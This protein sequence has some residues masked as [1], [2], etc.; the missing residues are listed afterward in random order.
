MFN[1]YAYLTAHKKD[2]SYFTIEGLRIA[3]KVDK[4]VTAASNTA[5]I[6]VY[7][8]SSRTR[9]ELNECN[10]V[11]LYAGYG[12]KYSVGTVI[13]GSIIHVTSEA[14]E[15]EI[16]TTIEVLDGAIITKSATLAI[17]HDSG[18]LA[19]TILKQAAQACNVPFTLHG[20]TSQNTYAT[21]FSYVGTANDLLTKVCDRLGLEWSLQNSVL[22]IRPKGSTY[23]SVLTLDQTTGL[24]SIP[25]KMKNNS[26]LGGSG[27]LVQSLLRPELQPN[28]KV[29]VKSVAANMDGEYTVVTCSH[30]GDTH[31]DNWTTEVQV[32]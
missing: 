17:S 30:N 29:H 10:A 26:F 9:S 32:R 7:N 31:A 18:V 12:D 21:G 27:Y 19:T 14:K 15:T 3:F 22:D 4:S 2:G 20:F 24:I 1:R 8:L 23:G 11:I 28:T 13:N 16:V 25:I 6:V 5:T